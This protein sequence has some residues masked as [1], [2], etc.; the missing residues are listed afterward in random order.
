MNS[1]VYR[2]FESAEIDW[3]EQLKAFVPEDYCDLLDA[4]R[5]Q[6]CGIDHEAWINIVDK[7]KAYARLKYSEQILWILAYIIKHNGAFFNEICGR[8]E[9]EFRISDTEVLDYLTR[10]EDAG[11]L[12]SKMDALP[13]RIGSNTI[14]KVRRYYLK[15]NVL[16]VE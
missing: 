10:M 7:V 15:R 9:D 6:Y 12:T 1:K 14:R 5:M 11:I 13:S 3:E 4:L 16:G 8:T 2:K